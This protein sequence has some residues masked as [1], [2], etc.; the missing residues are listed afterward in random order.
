MF[1]YFRTSNQTLIP[2]QI[3]YWFWLTLPRKLKFCQPLLSFVMYKTRFYLKSI[4][5][6]SS[7]CLYNFKIKIVKKIVRA[8][9]VVENNETLIFV[10]YAFSK[11]LNKRWCR[12]ERPVYSMYK[13]YRTMVNYELV[14]N[15]T[16]SNQNIYFKTLFSWILLYIMFFVHL[17]LE[18]NHLFVNI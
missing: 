7:N 17:T 9:I 3:F 2:K 4:K 18:R 14:Y 11:L 5:S 15:T 16:L 10:S 8:E 6:Y 13:S 1:L 12:A